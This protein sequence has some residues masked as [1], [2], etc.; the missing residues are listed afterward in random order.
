LHACRDFDRIFK[1]AGINEDPESLNEDPKL[2]NE[3]PE[4]LNEDP[5][6]L[7]EDPESLNEDPES[8]NE[9]P[10]LLNEDPELL[11]EDPESLNED[12]ELLNEDPE[13]LNEDPESLDEDPG[14]IKVHRAVSTFCNKNNNY[15]RNCCVGHIKN[16]RNNPTDPV[17][18][19]AKLLTDTKI[20]RNF[21]IGTIACSKSPIGRGRFGGF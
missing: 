9:D 4:S 7:N 8:L 5:E 6:S 13:L 17:L 12:P 2:L 16:N 11:N 15:G 18:R 21:V 20:N 14:A 3:D 19:A 10:E 1:L